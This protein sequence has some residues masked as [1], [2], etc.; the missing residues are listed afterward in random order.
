MKDISPA[1]KAHYASGTTT[2]ATCVKATLT[3]GTVVATTS[4]DT[5]L[6][7]DGVLYLAAAGYLGSDVESSAALNPDNLEISGFM[8][9]PAITEE[10]IHSGIWDYAEIEMFEVN[11]NDLTMGKNILRSGTL[12]EVK[13]GRSKFTAELRGLMQA[14]SR[15]IVRLTTKDC[16][17]DLGD[18]RCK[19]PAHLWTVAGTVASVTDNRVI[20]DPNRTEVADW[21]TGGKLTFTSGLNAG[22]SMEVKQSMTGQMTLHERMPFEIVAGDAY[23]V[24]A[25]CTKRLIQ[26]CKAKFNNVLNFRGFPYVPGVQIYRVGKQGVGETDTTGG[27]GAGGGTGGGTSTAPGSLTGT[28]IS[29]GLNIGTITASVIGAATGYVTGTVSGVGGTGTL[30]G[31]AT[32]NANG[33]STVTGTVTG[34]VIGAVT[35]SVRQMTADEIAAMDT[36]PTITA[37]TFY[38]GAVTG[39]VLTSTFAGKLVGDVTGYVTQG[40][41][42]TVNFSGAS[43]Y[44]GNG[45][46]TITAP[47]DLVGN[48][49]GFDGYAALP[50]SVPK[51]DAYAYKPALWDGA[52]FITLAIGEADAPGNGDQRSAHSTS[53]TGGYQIAP[54]IVL[55]DNFQLVRGNGKYVGGNLTGTFSVST[56]LVTWQRAQV[57]NYPQH[58][59]Q[60]SPNICGLAFVG[61]R[62]VAVGEYLIIME[63]TDG[64]NWTETNSS[65][66]MPS[67]PLQYLRDVAYSGSKYV[68]VGYEGGGFGGTVFPIIYHGTDL[69]NMTRV[70]PPTNGVKDDAGGWGDLSGVIYRDGAFLAFG[71]RLHAESPTLL[72]GARSQ[73]YVLRSTDGGATWTDVS[74]YGSL[75]AGNPSGTS[76]GVGKAIYMNGKYIALGSHVDMTSTNGITWTEHQHVG[77]NRGFGV[78]NGSILIANQFQSPL[79]APAYGNKLVSTTDGINWSPVNN[80]IDL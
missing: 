54:A 46:S 11:Y 49:A 31:T 42:A 34:N 78:T 64:L 9:S 58:N 7:I 28:V 70:V 27:G 50:S 10:D 39:G 80:F 19:I 35:G 67:Q 29:A 60:G 20:N 36:T 59:I 32:T 71:S 33:T 56:D 5:D 66:S 1:L 14:Y 37:V 26:D 16:T 23:L 40:N 2:L 18:S 22:L 17:A 51:P 30:T 62:F 3:N 53:G 13:G 77:I 4:H 38:D 6:P 76:S 73:P 15:T 74:P 45:T 21:Y 65:L 57:T 72:M 25:G 48:Y 24:A 69:T 52:R 47:I 43:I 55:G 79:T 63:S 75:L 44:N 68:V 12:G 61:G 8:R 41:G